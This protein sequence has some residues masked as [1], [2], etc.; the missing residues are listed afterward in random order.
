MTNKVTACHW[1]PQR[2]TVM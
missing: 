2:A 1:S